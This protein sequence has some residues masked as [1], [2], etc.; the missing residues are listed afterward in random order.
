MMHIHIQGGS[1]NGHTFVYALTSY[2][3]ASLNIDRF[4]N[5]FHFLNQENI[6]IRSFHT[7]SV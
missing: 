7:S 2:A 5:L 3:S 1:K 4:S 6:I